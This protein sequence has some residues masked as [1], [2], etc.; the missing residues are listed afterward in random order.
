MESLSQA[1][2][3]Q[4][5]EQR[6]VLPGQWGQEGSAHRRKTSAEGSEVETDQ[7]LSSRGML[8][9]V[10]K[11]TDSPSFIHFIKLSFILHKTSNSKL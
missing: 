6:G 2:R 5:T 7:Q 9:I 1:G 8:R 3:D 4:A 11:I 10:M